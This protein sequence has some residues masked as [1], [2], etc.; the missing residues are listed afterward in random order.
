[1][2]RWLLPICC[3]L[4]LHAAIFKLD[5]GW[6]KRPA[7]TIPDSLEV[8]ISL[9]QL[10]PEPVEQPT[11]EPLQVKPP[12]AIAPLT[13]V[14]PK[15]QVV[16][17]P[18]APAPP[19]TPVAPQVPPPAEPAPQPAP[20]VETEAAA[21]MPSEEDPLPA[22][23]APTAQEAQQR[24]A[25]EQAAVTASVPLYHL[26]PPPVYPAV[27]RRRNYEGTVVIDVLVDR[28]G[29]AAQVRIAHSSGYEILDRSAVNSVKQWRFAPG[30][31][32][33][34]P[35]EMWVQVPVRFSLE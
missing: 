13:P 7:A 23:A 30:R 24:D 6:L 14:E 20:P 29:R 9:V 34:Q 19:P 18:P 17:Q 35:V 8:T 27:A 31:R 11:I 12:A 10:M 21:N 16:E 2:K 28:Q 33:G 4:A 32:F 26:N 1:V 22:T 15:K 5:A 3:A 25:E